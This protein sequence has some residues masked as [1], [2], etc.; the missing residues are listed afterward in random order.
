MLTHLAMALE[1]SSLASFWHACPR[2]YGGSGGT[3]SGPTYDC[4]PIRWALL[5]I[6]TWKWLVSYYFGWQWKGCA[7]IVGKKRIALVCDNSPLIGWVTRLAS[8]WSLVAKHLVQ[9]LALCLKIQRICPLNPIRI[10]GKHN[11]ISDVPSW[12][13]ESNPTWKCDMDADLLFLFNPMFPLPHQNSWT[14]FHL[15]CKVVMRVIS[16]LRTKPFAMDDWRRLPKVG[17]HVGKIG[18]HMSNHWGWIRT[19]TTHPSKP[20]CAASPAS[21]SKH[22]LDSMEKDNKSRVALSLRQSWPLAR[23][24]LWPA[25][26]IPQ[27]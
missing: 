23:Q 13:S 15:N 2:Y 8:K 6:P 22:G 19:L 25:T 16:A 5:Q 18:A 10:K 9:A 20:K 17:R 7:D 11:A 26:T 1:G 24:E 21:H 12:S 4:L 14:I 3:T 27:R